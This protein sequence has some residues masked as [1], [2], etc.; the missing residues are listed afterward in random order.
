[1][2]KR[3]PSA[4]KRARQSEKRRIQNRIQ[5][6]KLKRLL[7]QTKSTKDNEEFK[8][9]LPKVQQLVDK[10]AKKGIIHKNKAARIK[11]KL[12]QSSKQPNKQI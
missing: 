1:M 5:K 12:M 2:A 8:K 6:L 3:T 10:L 11:S 7:K 9:L 4:L